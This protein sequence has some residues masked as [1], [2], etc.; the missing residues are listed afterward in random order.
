MSRLRNIPGWATLVLGLLVLGAASTA[1]DEDGK[2]APDKCGT[3]PLMIY[4]VQ[5]GAQDAD[6][7]PCVTHVGHAISEILP[8]TPSGGTAASGGSAGK[9]GSAAKG[10][11]A[12]KGS[13]VGLAGQGGDAGTGGA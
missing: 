7:N 5:G 12:G 11:S 4:D 9:G 13:S 6:A 10:G 1:C 3:P 8:A 2:T